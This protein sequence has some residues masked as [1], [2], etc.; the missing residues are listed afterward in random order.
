MTAQIL[1]PIVVS[2]PRRVEGHAAQ[3]AVVLEVG[4]LVWV[5]LKV[6]T[7]VRVALEMRT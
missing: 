4:A 1:V 3:P 7:L 5:T 6:R 2:W